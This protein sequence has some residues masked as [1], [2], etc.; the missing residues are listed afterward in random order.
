MH[1]YLLFTELDTALEWKE[2]SCRG[3]SGFPVAESCEAI[4]KMATF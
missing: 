2:E 4:N 3:T 1:N